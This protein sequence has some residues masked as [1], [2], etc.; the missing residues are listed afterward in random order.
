MQHSNPAAGDRA[1]GTAPATAAAPAGAVLLIAVA[2]LYLG[3]DIFIPLA[4][5]VLIA[6]VL[7]PLVLRLRHAGLSRIPSVVAAVLVA[8]IVLGGVAT[9][10]GTQAME[11]AG[12]LPTYRRTIEEKLGALRRNVAG[13]GAV[14]RVTGMLRDLRRVIVEPRPAPV[15]PVGRERQQ[16]AG[17]PRREPIPVVIESGPTQP[18]DVAQ[19]VL[20]PLL[21]PLGTAGLV[22][23][24]V[25]FILLEREDLRDRF[26]K[27]AGRGDLQRSTE[28]ISDAAARVSRYLVAQLMVNVSY[29][30]PIG[31]GLWLIGVPNAAL[32]G[33]LAAVLRFIPYLGPWLAALFPIALAFAVDPGWWMLAWVIA[34]FLIMELFSNNVVEP[35]LYGSSTGLSAFAVIIA[36]I[37]WTTLWGPAGL[38]LAT[39]LTVCLVVIGRYVQGLEFLGVLLGND[40]VLAPEERFYQ[41][42]L[43]GNVEEAIEMAEEAIAQSSPVAFLDAVAL[44]AL[45]HLDPMPGLQPLDRKVRVGLRKVLARRRL[46]R[47]L[48]VLVIGLPR[49]GDDLVQVTVKPLESRIQKAV[50]EPA[51]ELGSGQL[52]VRHARTNPDAWHGRLRL[53]DRIPGHPSA[54]TLACRQTREQLCVKVA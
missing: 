27:L 46:T 44:P 16:V 13:G 35:W 42:L 29:G 6:F 4:L 33:L 51:S 52:H 47:V 7:T 14:E 49:H 18:L 37:F 24:F 45:R 39:P 54:K 1:P 43:A 15:E 22:I 3:R 20:G 38:F 11:L 32:W 30:V 8:F 48:P 17:P 28:A 5:A 31:F 21:G 50:T 25:V 23:V 2:V 12:N 53:W 19:T 26:I 10:V 40:P 41:R 34:L 36:A 9:V